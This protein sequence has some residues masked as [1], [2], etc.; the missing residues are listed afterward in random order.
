MDTIEDIF[1]A[2]NGSTKLARLAGLSVTTV[3]SWK[4]SRNGKPNIPEWRRPL[5]LETARR[6]SIELSTRAI[7]YLSQ[8]QSAAA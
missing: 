2:F 5:V 8:T 4:N 6:N 1:K 7:L 3:D